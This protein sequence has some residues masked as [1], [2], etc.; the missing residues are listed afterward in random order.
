MPNLLKR[1]LDSRRLRSNRLPH[2]FGWID[3]RLLTHGYLSRSSPNALALYCLLI[4][5]ADSQGLSFYS[6]ERLR[7]ILGFNPPELHRA[8]RELIDSALIAYQKP[9]YQVLTLED[10]R[11]PDQ[12]PPPQQ[13]QASLPT[14]REL[15]A[16]MAASLQQA[17]GGAA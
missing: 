16:R 12:L 3:H 6:E 15:R 17:E 4:C 9:L 2:G 5:A 14:G 10:D 8:R 7:Q 13:Q 11:R 1:P